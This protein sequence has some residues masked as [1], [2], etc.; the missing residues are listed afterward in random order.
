MEDGQLIRG[1]LR[2]ESWAQKKIYEHYAPAMM[3]VCQRYTGDR[4]TARDLL[5]DG[6]VKLFTKIHTY[7]GSGSFS[8]WI[9]RIFVTTALEY[10]RRND[11][12]KYS[13]DIETDGFQI[14]SMDPSAL[15]YLSSDDLFA[16]VS[17]LPDGFRT[18]FNLYAVEGYSHAEIAVMLEI[19]ESTSRSQYTRARRLLQKRLIKYFDRETARCK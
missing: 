17:A 12:L 9:R 18:V 15:E 13:T 1:C 7:S 4:E 19:S 11:A 5:H 14:E 8:G 6:F 16:C 2:G 10:L 3:S